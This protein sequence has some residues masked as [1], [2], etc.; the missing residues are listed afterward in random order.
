MDLLI[1]QRDMA[2]RRLTMRDDEVDIY[3]FRLIEGGRSDM[4]YI[5]A[6]TVK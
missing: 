2:K 6:V 1:E 4:R 3:P 5:A